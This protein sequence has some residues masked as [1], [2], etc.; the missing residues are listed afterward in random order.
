MHIWRKPQEADV[1]TA[2]TQNRQGKEAEYHVQPP[3]LMPIHDPE[4]EGEDFLCGLARKIQ[5][6]VEGQRYSR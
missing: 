6:Q 5:Q 1:D 3:S 4:A 2:Y